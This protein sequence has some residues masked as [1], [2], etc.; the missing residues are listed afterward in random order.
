MRTSRKIIFGFLAVFVI[1]S[2]L[3]YTFG[4][5][6][7]RPVLERK[8]TEIFN[9]PVE[10]E[11]LSV[12]FPAGIRLSNVSIKGLFSA[13]EV[14]VS[15]SLFDIFRKNIRLSK[16]T[17]VN[18]TFKIEN[19][20]SGAVL[21]ERKNDSFGY[22]P[23]Q[24]ALGAVY[25]QA[26]VMNPVLDL[27]PSPFNTMK[28]SFSENRLSLGELIIKGG[29]LEVIDKRTGEYGISFNI[30]E[31]NLSAEN[32]NFSQ[33]SHEITSF[34][35]SGKIPWGNKAESGSIRMQGWYN[36]A[37]KDMQADLSIQNIDGVYLYPYYAQ[38]VDLEAARIESAKL[39]F[40]SRLLGLNNNLTAQCRL[41]L[42]DIQD[43]ERGEDERKRRAEM[44]KG[45]VLRRLSLDEEGKVA[46][47]FVVNTKIDDPRFGFV[48]IQDAVTDKLVKA[49]KSRSFNPLAIIFIPG[50]IVEEAV[51]STADISKAVIGGA[52]SVGK[53]LTGALIGSFKKEDTS[54]IE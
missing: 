42:T 5:V 52:F 29:K 33:D 19:D 12:S 30:E 26:E 47:N 27:A 28:N 18:P 21:E 51:K 3:S 43:K 17:I 32:I 38:W 50:K 49:G 34:N 4:G 48:N 24:P 40:N 9:R 39:N 31:F 13:E 8:L 45:E 35:L 1:L 10:I 41:E 16:V 46:V 20:F 37:K 22:Q 53:E 36:P 14:A 54:N 11:N 2:I 44:I 23:M 6:F 15:G 25:A 7:A